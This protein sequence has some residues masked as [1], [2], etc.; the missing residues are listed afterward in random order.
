MCVPD[1][2][3]EHFNSTKASVAIGIEKQTMAVGDGILRLRYR[4]QKDHV[5]LAN[6]FLTYSSP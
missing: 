1:A 3:F 5:L 2:A 4:N 6:L